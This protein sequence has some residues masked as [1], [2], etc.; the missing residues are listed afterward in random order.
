MYY[1]RCLKKKVDLIKKGVK[2]HEKLERDLE[3]RKDWPDLTQPQA[4]ISPNKNGSQLGSAGSKD[5]QVIITDQGVSDANQALNSLFST[6]ASICHETAAVFLNP[7]PYSPKRQQQQQQL[8]NQQQIGGGNAVINLFQSSSTADSTPNHTSTTNNADNN[9]FDSALSSP[10][11]NLS[12]LSSPATMTADGSTAG[13]EVSDSSSDCNSKFVS[14]NSVL[15]DTE[16][17]NHLPAENL[18]NGDLSVSATAG[19]NT[20]VYKPVIE[21]VAYNPNLATEPG[22]KKTCSNSPIPYR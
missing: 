20:N 16:P 12:A 10:V 6:P 22:A 4:A 7:P 15:I 14:C 18:T 13:L 21:P 9:K 3:K 1:V 2:K 17:N 5:N 11:R 19:G 8:S